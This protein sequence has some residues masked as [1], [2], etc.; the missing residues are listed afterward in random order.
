MTVFC[1]LHESAIA[2][3]KGYHLYGALVYGAYLALHDRTDLAWKPSYSLADETGKAL[4]T[5]FGDAKLK[6]LTR[7]GANMA[8]DE[9][10]AMSLLVPHA[11]P[12]Q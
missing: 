10:S 1:L 9:L 7:R 12:Q 2:I 8:L 4:L 11:L 3:T 5:Y 6:E